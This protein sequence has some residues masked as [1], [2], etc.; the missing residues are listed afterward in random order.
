MNGTQANMITNI[1]AQNRS[2]ARE[3]LNMVKSNLE[4][5]IDEKKVDLSDASNLETWINKTMSS[6]KGLDKYKNISLMKVNID[7]N[8]YYAGK[9]IWLS[10]P[11]EGTT[12]TIDS[13]SV[14]MDQTKAKAYL[15]TSNNITYKQIS[16]NQKLVD[17]LIANKTI[18]FKNPQEV[19][20]SLNKMYNGYP[21]QASDNYSWI[22]NNDSSTKDLVEWICVPENNQNKSS[23]G[24]IN[25]DY[26]K[27]AII[28]FVDYNYILKPYEK[29]LND[30]YLTEILII[31]MLVCVI[32]LTF[33][34][35]LIFIWK[36]TRKIKEKE[37][38]CDRKGTLPNN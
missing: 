18:R 31:V 33:I 10:S 22:E 25:K 5:D 26:S 36:S 15:K 3:L 19:A 17:E 14:I 7:E 28:A 32:I 34:F 24:V 8:N 37:D 30:Y 4:E 21:S 38:W 23:N 20:V 29:T 13:N 9:F 6:V 1:E 2:S 12:K 27:V 35:M 16:S 11:I